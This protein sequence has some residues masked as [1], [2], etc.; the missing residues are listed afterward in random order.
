M[1]IFFSRN[2]YRKSRWLSLYQFISY[3]YDFDDISYYNDHLFWF[4]IDANLTNQMELQ[5]C[6][7]CWLILTTKIAWFSWFHMKQFFLNGEQLI[8]W[9]VF[10]QFHIGCQEPFDTHLI[11]GWR[12][13]KE[14]GGID[15]TS[16]EFSKLNF[17]NNSRYLWIEKQ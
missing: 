6:L 15:I 5:N 4:L 13:V 12:K 11:Q 16:S 10:L 8:F 7:H 17:S 14:F 2:S 9:T 1:G 3:L